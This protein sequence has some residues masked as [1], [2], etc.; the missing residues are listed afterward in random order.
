[1]EVEEDE[2]SDQG[3]E[4]TQS[5]DEASA[6]ARD[7]FAEGRDEPDVETEEHLLHGNICSYDTPGRAGLGGP[8]Y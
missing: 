6:R 7:A 8:K 2:E 3:I 5:R 1:M 4:Q